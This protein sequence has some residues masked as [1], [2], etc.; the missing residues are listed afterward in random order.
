MDIGQTL[1]ARFA[2]MAPGLETPEIRTQGDT[3]LLEHEYLANTGFSQAGIAG[4]I[5]PDGEVTSAGF[6]LFDEAAHDIIRRS[7]RNGVFERI[8]PGP[9]PERPWRTLA[10]PPTWA[11]LT[12]P[13]FAY[14]LRMNGAHDLGG[15]QV[16]IGASPAPG[17]R[18]RL[19]QD[20]LVGQ[21][22]MDPG[23]AT[24]AQVKCDGMAAILEIGVAVP[25][26]VRHLLAGRTL[27]ALIQLRSSGDAHLDALVT[28][29]TIQRAVDTG[30]D[31]PALR[32]HFTPTMWMAPSQ[33]PPGAD[34]APARTPP[35]CR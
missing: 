33:S 31:A 15:E 2:R 14:A 4:G 11:T 10:K 29:L 35:P 20:L 21:A 22:S 3:I 34:M 17:V 30:G 27:G 1:Q 24:A 19:Q 26:A 6:R 9:E 7:A 8:S 12:H 16:S 28:S 32:I 18:I 13:M 23:H 5:G 25:E